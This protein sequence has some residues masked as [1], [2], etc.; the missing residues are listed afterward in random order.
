MSFGIWLATVLWLSSAVAAPSVDLSGLPSKTRSLIF[1]DL[2]AAAD[3]ERAHGGSRPLQCKSDS[4]GFRLRLLAPG[5]PC[6]IGGSLI[7][8]SH[9]S[10]ALSFDSESFLGHQSIFQFTAWASLIDHL[11]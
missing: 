2:F 9:G 4:G 5:A 3:S 8:I 10:G 7:D 6:H 1:I 11:S